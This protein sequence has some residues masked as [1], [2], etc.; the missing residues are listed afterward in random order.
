MSAAVRIDRIQGNLHPGFN[1]DQQA[2][3]GLRFPSPDRARAW[4]RDTVGELTSARDVLAFRA[5]RAGKTPAELAELRSTWINVAFSRAGLD[6]LMPG[7]SAAFPEAF[8]QGMAHRA[9]MLADTP[10]SWRFGGTGDTEAHVLMVIG[11][12]TEPDLQRAL[13]A[14]RDRVALHSGRDVFLDM[15]GEDCRG[16]KLPETRRAQEHF[17]YRDGI[18]EPALDGSPGTGDFV[19]GYPSADGSL[20][21][22]G[23]AWT[24][25]GSYVVFRRLRQDVAGFH[26]GLAALLKSTGLKNRA[27]LGAKVVGRWPSGAKL[28]DPLGE[29]PR[30]ASEP[31][32]Y[33]ADDYA[34]DPAGTRVPHFA[35]VR[36]AHPHDA[37][38]GGLTHRL[39]R[40][41]IPYGPPLDLGNAEAPPADDG[42]DRG[43]L[44]LAFQA[45]LGAQYE[46]VQRWLNDKNLPGPGAGQDPV[47]GQGENPTRLV[48]RSSNTLPATF[49]MHHYV[50][51]TGGGY[52]FVPSITAAR[53]LA[54]PTSTWE[55]QEA[56]M[57]AS[58]QEAL[59]T[60]IV[61]ENP[62]GPMTSVDGG[63]VARSGLGKARKADEPWEVP[64]LPT[65][66]PLYLKGFFW[67]VADDAG[68]LETIRV[69]KAIRIKYMANGREYKL[70]VGYEG[71]AGV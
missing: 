68:Q 19:L 70:L 44:F 58:I 62:Y 34:A 28:Q 8:V 11:A 48:L 53:F 13:R 39:L 32:P 33:T 18:S 46:R 38:V 3:L 29:I 69:S 9:E 67:P 25:D 5:R 7:A 31:E 12:D 14:H 57:G 43:L 2:F 21:A 20:S 37:A 47:A 23:P 60:V 51:M 6:F 42:R 4:L 30:Q 10:E 56:T 59:G 52:F 50:T 16:A 35:H 15:L 22:S 41:G 65:N 64:E 24:R 61:N 27:Q 40:R 63:T 17:G 36:K 26:Q 54:D 49:D 55:H 1:K 45:D 71:G 66:H